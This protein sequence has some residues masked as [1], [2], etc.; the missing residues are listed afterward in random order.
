MSSLSCFAAVGTLRKKCQTM[1]LP[2][3][4]ASTHDWR[5]SSQARHRACGL[6]GC[7]VGWCCRM[8][9]D[10]QHFPICCAHP[11]AARLVLLALS[12]RL[13]MALGSF[14]FSLSFELIDEENLWLCPSTL[15]QGLE[16]KSSGSC[17]CLSVGE[18]W[19]V[20]PLDSV[21][22]ACL[23]RACWEHWIAAES[24]LFNL[25]LS[26]PFVKWEYSYFIEI[27]RAMCYHR[28]LSKLCSGAGRMT[29]P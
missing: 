10:E 23:M 22:I 24:K 9:S 6:S 16:K 21:S 19:V 2:G 29:I 15:V 8:L 5:F 12:G 7:L 26:T 27:I 18:G 25:V 4:Q 3:A 11:P 1:L 13:P 14:L 28:T 20:R 17:L